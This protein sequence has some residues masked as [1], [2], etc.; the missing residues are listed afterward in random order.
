MESSKTLEANIKE[1][2][3]TIRKLNEDFERAQKSFEKFNKKKQDFL[4]L[5]VHEKSGRYVVGGILC[6]LVLIFD[7]WVSHRSLEYLS[8]IIRV[9]KE[10]LALLFSVLDGFL[11]IF[12]SGGFAGPDSSKKEKHRKSG[13]PI[14]ILLGLVKIILFIIL[15]VNKY[16]EI[17]PVTSQE[18][19]TLSTIDSIKII[20]PQVIFV[21]IVYSILSTNGFGL[22]YILGL[23]YYGI[24]QLLLVNPESVK[25]KMRKAFNSLKEIAKD[26]F[27]DI[28]SREELWDIY[29]KVFEKNE[30]KNGQN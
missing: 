15:V 22:W 28:L 21:I 1:K 17:D 20:G 9:P 25:F 8:D 7:Y 23:G 19:Y 24:Y 18:I 12:A 16:T 11:A 27:N 4:E 14:L 6:L 29:Y 2:V 30:V 10:F 3:S 26:Q 13:I 5:F